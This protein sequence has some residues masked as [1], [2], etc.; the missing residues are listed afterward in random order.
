MLD[1][2]RAPEKPAPETLVAFREDLLRPQP[3]YSTPPHPHWA[4]WRSNAAFFAWALSTCL[5]LSGLVFWP[6]LSSES[7]ALAAADN[8]GLPRL[9]QH[10]LVHEGYGLDAIAAGLALLVL[11]SYVVC[12]GQRRLRVL[13]TLALIGVL[14]L[15]FRLVQA[16][17][18]LA[19][20]A[21]IMDDAAAGLLLTT[22]WPNLE[23]L[24]V[25]EHSSA[26]LSLRPRAT[27]AGANLHTFA[28]FHRH[29][30]EQYRLKG[31][32]FAKES[33]FADEAARKALFFMNFVS[34]LW[35]YGNQVAVDKTGGALSNE[36]N[37]WQE[38]TPSLQAYLASE[39]GCCSDYA[40]L[41]KSLLD[42][43]GIENRL[44]T[45]PGHVFNEAKLNGRWCMLDPTTNIFLETTW[46]ELY[47]ATEL[48]RDSL[49]VHV[50]PHSNLTDVHSPRYRS[51]AGHFRL[52]MLSRI[53][54]RPAAFQPTTH[55]D[56][57]AWFD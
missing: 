14:L 23:H 51:L 38:S 39:I 37:N 11:A 31:G 29:V 43:E 1:A 9:S 44:T 17:A 46:E 42:H 24:R 35:A 13:R 57:P 20:S 12:F 25:I 5:L 49:T 28:D 4:Y 55:P 10:K 26:W 16:S 15:E 8:S 7:F 40:Y 54:N 52:M 33:P 27:L 41:L 45:I 18:R 56:L 3:N 21:D 36:A 32:R 34:G 30:V 53:A 6:L 50:F 19:I 48:E 2:R 22:E 47:A